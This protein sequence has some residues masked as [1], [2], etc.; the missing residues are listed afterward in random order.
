MPRVG[1][2]RLVLS[3]MTR[4]NAAAAKYTACFPFGHKQDLILTAGLDL[5]LAKETSRLTSR[6]VI[7]N[8]EDAPCSAHFPAA[9]CYHSCSLPPPVS[10]GL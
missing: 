7:C 9:S 10:D 6:S 3:S 2:I 5:D 4:R 1:R 8:S